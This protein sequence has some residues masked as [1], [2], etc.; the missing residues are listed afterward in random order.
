MQRNKTIC[1]LSRA[2]ILIESASTGGSMEAG[3]AALKMGTPLY[4]P[5]YDS[6]PET[7]VGNRELL[8]QGAHPLLKSRSTGRANM[9][10]V[11]SVVTG[12]TDHNCSEPLQYPIAADSAS[13]LVLFEQ[14]QNEYHKKS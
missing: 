10:E 6:M 11:L 5:V 2:M 7:A 9:K 8:E 4:A 14:H 12:S 3:R 1:A 13:Q